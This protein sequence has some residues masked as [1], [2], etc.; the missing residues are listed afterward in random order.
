[1]HRLAPTTSI[2]SNPSSASTL[3]LPTSGL[4]GALS[5][6]SLITAVENPWQTL[7]VFVL[8]LFNGEQLG[9]PIEDLNGLVKEHINAVVSR[10]TAGMLTLSAKLNNLEDEKLL[11]RLIEIWI[12]FY[13]QVL[14]YVEGV[15]LPVHT[16]NLILSLNRPKMNRAASPA[17]GEAPV[18]GISSHHIDVRTLTLRAFRDKVLIPLHPRVS[19]LL[20]SEKTLFH[21]NVEHSHS[22]LRQMLLVL[23][24]IGTSR[25]GFYDP[26]FQGPTSGEETVF[27]L[28]RATN[29]A[30]GQSTTHK[31]VLEQSQKQPSFVSAG[32]PRD[33]RGRIARKS[34]HIT[35]PD[36]VDSV[37]TKAQRDDLMLERAREKQLLA[38][39]RS[40]NPNDNEMKIGEQG[41]N[42]E[43]ENNNG[44]EG[45]T[46]DNLEEE[47]LKRVGTLGLRAAEAAQ[48]GRNLRKRASQ[49]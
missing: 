16:D 27:Q 41:F 28:L 33:R 49:I 10:V 9:Q 40:P 30:S 18:R 12:L 37:Y 4:A 38:G 11:S 44:I 48:D 29:K 15:F 1:M 2:G 47:L 8:P 43:H 45:E 20:S 21:E 3:S 42:L 22:R 5:S 31:I 19:Y 39:L 6:S 14:P 17:L 25:P 26:S 46:G 24:S 7:H 36:E 23:V 35:H 34:V 13:D 32:I